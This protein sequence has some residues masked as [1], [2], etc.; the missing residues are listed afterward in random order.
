MQHYMAIF[1]FEVRS[2]AGKLPIGVALLLSLLVLSLRTGSKSRHLL[3][4]PLR[5]SAM[6]PLGPT[7]TSTIDAWLCHYAAG[8]SAHWAR[9]VV[10]RKVATLAAKRDLEPI[11]HCDDHIMPF[12][13][14]AMGWR[15]GDM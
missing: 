7:P 15:D 14:R 6:P 9:I 13:D 8:V 10:C 4:V 2:F 3:C 12:F 1:G 11:A 5:L